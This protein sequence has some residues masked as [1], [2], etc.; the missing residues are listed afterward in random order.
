MEK[1]LFFNLDEDS[2]YFFSCANLS[3]DDL[4]KLFNRNPETIIYKNCNR[5]GFERVFCVSEDN[6]V[7]AS[8]YKSLWDYLLVNINLYKNI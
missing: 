5:C 2:C 6:Q 7:V 4:A 3:I 8:I 1:N